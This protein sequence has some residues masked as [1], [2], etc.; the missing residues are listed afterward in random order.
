MRESKEN[1]WCYWNEPGHLLFVSTNGFVKKNGDAVMGRG[2]AKEA[3][4]RIRACEWFLGQHINENGNI[5]TIL[6]LKEGELGIL[7]VKHNWWEEADLALIRISAK[8]VDEL[9]FERGNWELHIP[10]LGC[11]NGKLRWEEV[12]PLL[13]YLPDNVI[14]HSL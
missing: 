9:A 12:H 8:Y 14:V 1:L 6:K 7:P 5:P 11:G 3:K 4:Q 13:S 10:R 2:C